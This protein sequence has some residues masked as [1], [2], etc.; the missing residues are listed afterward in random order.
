MIEPSI[1]PELSESRWTRIGARL[2]EL[3]TPSIVQLKRLWK[4]FVII[5]LFGAAIVIAY[6][7]HDGFARWCDG[8]GELKKRWG[9]WF[10]LITMP[11]SSAIVP[12]VMKAITGVE[13]R[14][15]R[16]KMRTIMFHLFIFAISGM[17]SDGLYRLLAIWPGNSLDV[18]T[19]VTKVVIDQFIYTPLIGATYLAF[20]YTFRVSGFSVSRTRAVVGRR[21]YV[22]EVVPLLLPCWAFWI[23]MCTLM[24][25]LPTS[26]TY[27]FGVTANAAAVTILIAVVGRKK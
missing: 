2:R 26:L 7:F 10:P 19:V 18:A 13:R 27:I 17:M 21:W 8:V 15:D 24:Y 5:Q 11:I 22:N 20:W 16:E 6:F 3:G 9:I 25:L 14:F 1:S 23:P 4:P 12:E